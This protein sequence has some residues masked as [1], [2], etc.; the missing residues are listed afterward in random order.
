MKRLDDKQLL[1]EIHLQESKVHYAL[2]N[3]PKARAALTAGRASANSIYVGPELQA[4]ID[5][6]AGTLSCEE[7]DYRTGAFWC[8]SSR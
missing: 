1:V 5:M 3:T 2:K 6:Q 8:G 7:R 4:D